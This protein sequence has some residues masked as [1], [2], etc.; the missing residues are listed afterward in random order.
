M[1]KVF[2]SS[3]TEKMLMQH[4][5]SISGDKKNNVRRMYEDRYIGREMALLRASRPHP[6]MVSHLDE[7]DGSAIE[8]YQFLCHMLIVTHGRHLFVHL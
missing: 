8:E 1:Q 6:P 3:G 4:V 5:Q 7:I 2:I